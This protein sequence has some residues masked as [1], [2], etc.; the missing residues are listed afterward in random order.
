MDISNRHIYKYFIY[1]Y[2]HIFL[3]YCL[4]KLALQVVFSVIDYIYPSKNKAMRK[5]QI[6]TRI[7]MYV[8]QFEFFPFSQHV[9]T[10]SSDFHDEKHKILLSASVTDT[11]CFFALFHHALCPNYARCSE[12]HLLGHFSTD[13]ALYFGNVSISMVLNIIFLIFH[14]HCLYEIPSHLSHYHHHPSG[15]SQFT[16]GM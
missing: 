12:G 1:A 6:S 9:Q 14:H 10:V 4:L 11:F 3:S 5:I 13:F 2:T 7:L 15:S 16:I 8:K